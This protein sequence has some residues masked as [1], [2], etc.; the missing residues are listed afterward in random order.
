MEAEAE[1]PEQVAPA[2]ATAAGEPTVEGA[3]LGQS[4][5]VDPSANEQCS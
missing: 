3:T 5:R 1:A 2:G 4:T